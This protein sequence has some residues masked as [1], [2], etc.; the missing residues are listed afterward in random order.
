MGS[1]AWRLRQHWGQPSRG[2]ERID[3][4]IDYVKR[5]G[6]AIIT[7]NNRGNHPLSYL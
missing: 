3:L 7:L 6:I 2:G 1:G 5:D 4:A